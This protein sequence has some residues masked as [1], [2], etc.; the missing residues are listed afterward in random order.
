M[1][2]GQASVRVAGLWRIGGAAMLAWW[3]VISPAAAE[4]PAPA[5]M[6]DGLRLAQADNPASA[7][8]PASPQ[9]ETYA[10]SDLEQMLGPIALYPDPLLLLIFEASA[11]PLQIVQA[12]RWLTDNKDVVERGDFSAVDAQPWEASVKALTR[13]PEVV[14]MLADYLDWTESLGAAFAL[15]PSDVSTAVQLLRAQAEKAGNLQSTPQQTV[16]VAEESGSRVIYIAP[17]NPERIY[18]PVYDSA[19]VF[20]S[21]VPGA[22]AF[23][24]GVLVGS[25]WNNRWGWNNRYWN[26]VWV[27][28]PGWRRPPN[29]RPRPPAVR[30][31]G[32]GRPGGVRPG[33]PGVRPDRPG[34]RPGRPGARPDRP[35]ARPDRPGRPDARPDRPRP[36]PDRPTAR[37]G[38]PGQPGARPDRPRPD[39]PA[40]RPNRP[41]QPGA[42]PDRPRPRPDRPAARPNRPS[43]PG[44]APNRP[45]ARPGGGANRASRPAARPQRPGASQSRSGAGG[46]RARPQGGSPPRRRGQSTPQ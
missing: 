4:L 18:V 25:A 22:L 43:Q 46:Q 20:Q 13:F 38:R 21:A 1:T 19:R 14:E 17:A 23:G 7:P 3:V 28:P 10:I 11:F 44:A 9:R 26:R 34:T 29:W 2:M 45:T 41:G 8:A 30:P 42:R 6:K 24:T 35:G 15:Q 31:P 32:I 27:A 16:R 39:R 12:D 36:R 40:A 5:G 33:R 37:P